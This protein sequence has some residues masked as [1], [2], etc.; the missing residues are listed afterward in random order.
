MSGE[1]LVLD[2]KSFAPVRRIAMSE[3]GSSAVALTPDG[4]WGARVDYYGRW[5]LELYDIENGKLARDIAGLPLSHRVDI[6]SVAL[7][8]DGSRVIVTAPSI[9]MRMWDTATGAPLTSS[10]VGA[11]DDWTT[12]TADGF[13]LGSQRSG[14]WLSVVRGLEPYSVDQ[15]RDHLYRPDLVAELLKGDPVR[16]YKDAAHA[17]NLEKILQSGSAPQIELH[18]ERKTEQ[19]G[20]SVRVTVRI[21]DTGG[22]IGEKVIW[23]VNGV[24]QGGSEASAQDQAAAG[25]YRIVTETLKVDPSR[26]NAIEVTAYN[27]AGLLA[28]RPLE[29]VID[30]FGVSDAPRPRMF[31]LAVGVSDYAMKDWRLQYAA[32]DAA[33]FAKTMKEAAHGLYGE[34]ELSLVPEA[35][36]TKAGIEAAFD[37][38]KDDV[39]PTDVFVLFVAGHGRTVASTGTYYFLPRDLTFEGGRSV[40]DGIGQETWQSWLKQITAQK[41]VLIF[42]TCESSAAAGLAR[43]DKERETAIDRLR[44]ATGRSV[45]TASRQ[46]AY[47][48]YKGHGVLTYAVLDAL[49]AK[50]GTAVGEVDLLQ[51]AAHVDREVPAISQSLFGIRQRPHYKIEN[52]FP[53]G[54]RRASLATGSVETSIPATPTHVVIRQERVREEPRTDAPGERTLSPGTQVRVIE[55][56]AEWAIIARDGQKMGYIPLAALAALQ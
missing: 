13:F 47:E 4:R 45:L 9:G 53:I 51:L 39:Q 22:G 11:G 3:G 12:I 38:I 26:K 5:R 52:N 25:G 14:S 10:I 49:T 24:V 34:V 21:T 19:A 16:R 37:A 27:A 35:Q 32:S 46:A 7:S 20:G 30:P 48:G 40:E 33:A 55:L 43:G 29:I 42:D 54:I 56:K 31:V 50:E 2:R 44:N 6:N 15:F 36:A 17:L 1:I 28:S 18:P 23:R 41:S 8:P